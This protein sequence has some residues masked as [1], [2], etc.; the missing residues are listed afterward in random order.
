MLD[1]YAPPPPTCERDED[2]SSIS[3]VLLRW[4]QVIGFTLLL[5]GTPTL[6]AITRL[7][8]IES[9]NVSLTDPMAIA[10]GLV[11]PFFFIVAWFAVCYS[12]TAARPIPPILFLILLLPILP[13]C[14]YVLPQVVPAVVQ[15]A[16]E[17]IAPFP[18][19]TLLDWAIWMVLSIA[20]PIAFGRT[21]LS[22]CKPSTANIG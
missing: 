11:A 4:I 15:L 7:L 2:G 17:G 22:L 3:G 1:P 13:K 16:R 5:I 8:T 18:G 19:W 10:F 21:I 14:L 6:V 12:R 20:I 9:S